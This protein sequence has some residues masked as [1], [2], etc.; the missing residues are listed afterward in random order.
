MEQLLASVFASKKTIIFDFDGTIADTFHLHEMAFE[1]ALSDLRVQFQYKDYAGMSTKEAIRRILLQNDMLLTP[2][3]CSDLVKKKQQKANQLYRE[4][5]RFIPG[6][7][8]FLQ[9]V[10]KKGLTMVVASSGSKMNVQAGLEA[11]KIEALFSAVLTADDVPKAKPDPAIFQLALSMTATE[12]QH[13][14][15]IEDAISG[16]QAAAA[17]GIDVVCIDKLMETAAVNDTPFLIKDFNEL[18]NLLED[19]INNE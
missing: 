8:P 12:A 13:A 3:E 11:L 4:S 6:A 9:L 10:N 17:A 18:Y 16:I 19:T 2:E 15:V 5:I 7:L 1:Q 14:L